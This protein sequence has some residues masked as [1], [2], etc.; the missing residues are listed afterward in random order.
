MSA[1]GNLLVVWPW[2]RFLSLSLRTGWGVAETDV[3]GEI[4]PR[5]SEGKM[6]NDMGVCSV[7]GIAPSTKSPQ[8]SPPE[9]TLKYQ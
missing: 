5:G 8:M 4:S 7:D 2:E 6:G 3:L 1:M 9:E